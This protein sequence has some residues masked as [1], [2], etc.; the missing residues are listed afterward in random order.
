MKS[1]G[2]RLHILPNHFQTSPVSSSGWVEEPFWFWVTALKRQDQIPHSVYGTLQTQ[3]RL[4]YLP[5]HFRILH[6]SCL[7]WE[8]EPYCFWILESKVKV[9]FGNLSMKLVGMIKTTILP[10]HFQTS[11]VGCLWCEKEPYWFWVTKAKLKLNLSSLQE[12]TTLCVVQ[13]ACKSLALIFMFQ[14]PS[15]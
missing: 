12:H 11:I 3:Y 7:W 6:V 1:C 13:L 4:Q 5:N 10:N 15:L 9:K 2:H 8:E 14:F